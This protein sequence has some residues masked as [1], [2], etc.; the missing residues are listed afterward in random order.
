MTLTFIIDDAVPTVK[1]VLKGVRA[2][3]KATPPAMVLNGGDD[4]TFDTA[5]LRGSRRRSTQ[6]D[7]DVAYPAVSTSRE[8]HAEY[9]C[10]DQALKQYES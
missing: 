6:V 1:S 5:Q 3:W 4:V 7:A 2:R 9:R 10:G 8:V